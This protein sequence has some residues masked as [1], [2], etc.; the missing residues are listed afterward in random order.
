MPNVICE[1]SKGSNYQI[2]TVKFFCG[3]K[4]GFTVSKHNKVNYFALCV[5]G[6]FFQFGFKKAL[7]PLCRHLTHQKASIMSSE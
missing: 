1:S 6:S 5:Q 2:S 7:T 3:P 4:T